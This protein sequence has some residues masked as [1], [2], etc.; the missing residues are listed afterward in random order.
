[1]ASAF[2]VYRYLTSHEVEARIVYGGE[3]P[4]K[5]GN[6]KLLLRECDIPITHCHAPSDFDLLLLVDF[7]YGQ[8][9]VE[10]VEAQKIAIINHHIQK[11]EDTPDYLTKSRYQS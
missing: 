3:H 7:Q 6:M 1:M 5:K 9:N 2:G 10:R 8:S 11:I 4:I